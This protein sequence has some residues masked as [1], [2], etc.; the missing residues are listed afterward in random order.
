MALPKPAPILP[1][2]ILYWRPD[3]VKG[4]VIPILAEDKQAEIQQRVA[5]SFALRRRSKH[6]LECAKRTVELAIEQDEQTAM[7]W[8]ESQLK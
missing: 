5:E 6:L 7:K 1:R 2:V 4:T 3:Q 8:L